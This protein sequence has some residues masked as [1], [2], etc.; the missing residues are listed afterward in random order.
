VLHA[1][2]I[3]VFSILSHWAIILNIYRFI[4]DEFHLIK[5]IICCA[6]KIN[7]KLNNEFFTVTICSRPWMKENYFL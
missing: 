7:E 6:H 3:S 2:P 4:R 5:N 1:P